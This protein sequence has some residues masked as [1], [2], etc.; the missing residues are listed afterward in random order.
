MLSVTAAGVK[1]PYDIGCLVGISYDTW[2]VA[3][4]E[5]ICRHHARVFCNM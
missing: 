2:E 5:Q 1:I 3:A 4:F